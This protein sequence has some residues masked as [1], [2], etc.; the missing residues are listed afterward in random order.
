[1]GQNHGSG[2]PQ[3]KWH[4]V[5]ETFA[6]KWKEREYSCRLLKALSTAPS[7]ARS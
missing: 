1:M 3:G 5:S 7:R 4:I 6:V 2:N